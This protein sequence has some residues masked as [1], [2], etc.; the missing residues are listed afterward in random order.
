MTTLLSVQEEIQCIAKSYQDY[1]VQIRRHLHQYP[2]LSWQETQ[3]IAFLK[4]E[5]QK[6]CQATYLDTHLEEKK[7]GLVLD[8]T[9]DPSFDR[10]MFRADIDALPIQ[11]QTGLSFQSQHDGIMH[12][13]G[14]DCHAAML[15][16]GLKAL[17]EHPLTLKHNLRFVWQ[18]AEENPLTDSGAKT[19]IQED[20]LKD[21][22]KVYGLHITSRESLGAF[23][24]KPGPLMS[25]SA[26]IHFKIKCMGGHV[27]NP[28]Q[29]SNAIDII[30]DI[31]THLRGLVLSSLGPKEPISFVPSVSHAGSASNIMPNQGHATY[32]FRNFLSYEH[33]EQFVKML[34][35]R[36]LSLIHLYPD[37]ELQSFE[38]YPGYPV[39]ENNME[40]YELSHKLLLEHGFNSLIPKL[41]FSGEDFAYYLQERPG[42]FWL[43]GAAQGPQFDHHTS[44]FN[45]NE[46]ALWM[47]VCF[48]MLLA[49]NPTL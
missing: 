25:N 9:I 27:M 7:G 3:T 4:K 1:T 31:H 38:F 24:S 21:I 8:I 18:R 47:G 34:K 45:P 20:V 10:I 48:W 19:L 42:C 40:E 5:V 35:E 29:G 30:T 15:L 2:E 33:R 39:L 43:L 13:C 17:C 49:Q 41:M 22:S 12:A 26:H 28:D 37:A 16:G 6:I 14:H 11:E 46:E 36:I 44:L 32:S 23:V